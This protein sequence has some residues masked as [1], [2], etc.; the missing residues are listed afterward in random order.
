MSTLDPPATA[1][2]EWPNVDPEELPATYKKA[3]LM[4]QSLAQE[5]E[6][7]IERGWASSQ[8]DF[9]V[10]SGIGHAVLRRWLAGTSWPST[11]TVASAESVLELPLWPHQNARKPHLRSKGGYDYP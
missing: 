10:R 7:Y 6:H 5:I 4:R 8:S 1:Y 2:P 3:W 11:E 9:A